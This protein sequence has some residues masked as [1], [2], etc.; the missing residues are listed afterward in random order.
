MNNPGIGC[1]TYKLTKDEQKKVQNAIDKVEKLCQEYVIPGMCAVQ[2]GNGRRNYDT[3]F[4]CNQVTA[5]SDLSV[6]LLVKLV[7][8]IWHDQ[9]DPDWIAE[10]WEKVDEIHRQH[11]G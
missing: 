11:K 10:L 9:A 6:D 7:D 2:V 5:K 3:Y 4:F 1:L 8:L